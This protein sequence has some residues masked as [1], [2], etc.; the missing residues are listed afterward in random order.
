MQMLIEDPVTHDLVFAFACKLF[1][2]QSAF[3]LKKES[4]DYQRVYR[5]ACKRFFEGKPPRKRGETSIGD[6]INWEWV[7]QCMRRT[8]RNVILA[9]RDGDFGATYNNTCYLNDWLS[10]EVKEIDATLTVTLVSSLA[11]ALKLLSVRLSNEELVSE[12][13]M[14]LPQNPEA[15]AN[16]D[17][18]Q[19]VSCH[20]SARLAEIFFKDLDGLREKL[21]MPSGKPN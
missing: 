18:I 1:S 15:K 8:G 20:T 4:A 10:E 16:F 7:L 14:L 13:E 5:K 21:L 9:S 2:N 3:N 19:T 11:E 17:W 6:A 12:M